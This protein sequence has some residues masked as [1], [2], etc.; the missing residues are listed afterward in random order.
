M[1]GY[2]NSI[3]GGASRLIRKAI[4][5]P[6]FTAGISGWSINKDGSAEFNNGTFRGT[7]TASA[8]IIRNSFGAIVFQ[9]LASNGT[10][11][12]Y[13]DTG[14]AVQGAL[15][16]SVGPVFTDSFGNAVLS[17]TVSY[18]SAGGT[19][20]ASRLASGLME[21]LT[22]TSAAGPWT[23]RGYVR[24]DTSVFGGGG[25]ISLLSEAAAGAQLAVMDSGLF[26][27]KGPISALNANTGAAEIW[28][29]TA[30]LVNGWSKTGYF[31]YRLNALGN[32]EITANLVVGTTADFTVILST[33]LPLAYHPTTD[34]YIPV[35]TDQARTDTNTRPAA[36]LFKADGTVQCF[37][38]G[39][40]AAHARIS[41]GTY[42]L[43]I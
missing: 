36:L 4:Q 41:L 7:I 2:A 22:A 34:Q 18:G 1:S 42:P 17:G 30:A 40:T 25:G 33:A 16:A 20:F 14:S 12:T 11:L 10:E 38:I 3:L 31:K 15:I 13:A 24:Y 8:F 6:N 19:F 28:T 26:I 39:G 29:D 37:G 35:N 32:V 27:A 5:S 9:I 21:I 43:G 23:G